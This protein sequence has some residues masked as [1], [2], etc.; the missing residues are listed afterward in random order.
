MC[1]SHRP[2]SKITTLDFTVIDKFMPLANEKKTIAK[3]LP[4][5]T[6]DVNVVWL[7]EKIFHTFTLIDH[8]QRTNCVGV[9]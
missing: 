3:Q 8:K 5:I 1:G 7:T 2:T 4:Q 9:G 6:V